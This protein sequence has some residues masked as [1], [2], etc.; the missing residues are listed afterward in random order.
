MEKLF[1]SVL[2]LSIAA[3]WVIL[4][5]LAV[6][7]LLFK[8]LDDAG[9]VLDLL[10]GSFGPDDHVPDALTGDACVFR[11]LCQG[12]ILVVIEIEELLLSVCEELSVKI[13]QH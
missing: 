10:H 13:E 8:A 11:N 2:D 3:S 4:A 6:R 5:V 9:L 7:A 1:L 12:K